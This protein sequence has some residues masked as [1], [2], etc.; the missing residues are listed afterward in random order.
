MDVESDVERAAPEAPVHVEEKANSLAEAH[1]HVGWSLSALFAAPTPPAGPVSLA[2]A[3]PSP[4]LSAPTLR[5]VQRLAGNRATVAVME[6][7]R[8]RFGVQRDPE[9]GE[10]DAAPAADVSVTAVSLSAGTVTL[11]MAGDLR[12]T[13]VPDNATGVTWSVSAGTA[14]TANVAIDATT[15]VITIAAGQQGG[16]IEVVADAADGSG[17][18]VDLIMIERPGAVSAT[19]TSGSSSYGGAFTHTFTVP[20]GQASGLHGANINE[21][22]SSTS[23]T[24]PWGAFDLDVNAA[25][26]LGWDLD[27]SGKMTGP[28]NVDIGSASVDIG[29]LV[30]STSNPNP[31]QALPQ[32]FTMTQSLYAKVQPGGAMEGSA[33][34]TVSHRRELI[35]GPQFKVSAG[36]GSIIEDYVGA[37][38]VTNAAASSSTVMASPPRPESGTWAQRKVTV[39][40]DAIPDTATLTYSIRGRRLGCTIDDNGEVSIGVRAGTITVRVAATRSNYDEVTI[41]IT[42]YVDPE[43]PE[44]EAESESA[45]QPVPESSG[46]A[47]QADAPAPEPAPSPPVQGA[48]VED[49]AN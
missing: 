47:E 39:T 9:E 43:N 12:A 46:P 37:A 29:R 26:S 18:A 40:A 38:A 1:R 10:G 36:E 4:A 21:Q 27:S 14:D 24:A 45:P 31:T 8:D 7:I 22:F 48:P 42:R 5:N 13:A 44:A 28:D 30:N 25:G 19:D 35:D 15:G 41:A 34:A 20:S 17:A 32:G 49:A 23:A 16:T 2:M 6:R 11:P 33:F 3:G